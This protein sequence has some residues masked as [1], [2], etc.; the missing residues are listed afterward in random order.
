M[1]HGESRSTVQPKDI[2]ELVSML[3][4]SSYSVLTTKTGAIIRRADEFL[5]LEGE[6]RIYP[7]FLSN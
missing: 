6:S 2:S 1:A 7:G 4:N 3:A 5:F